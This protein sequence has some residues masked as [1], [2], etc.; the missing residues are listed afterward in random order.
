[1]KKETYSCVCIDDDR[2]FLEIL[3]KYIKNLDFLKLE[4][5]FTNPML[6]LNEVDQ[7]KPDIIFIDIDLP[8]INGFTFIDALDYNPI[9]IMITSHWEHAD[10]A[11]K[12]GIDAFITKPLKGT[13]QFTDTLFNA[14]A[15]R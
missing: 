15:K 1:M 14:I 5:T 8:E 6:A 7:S 10:T 3:S 13:E 12:H 9:V 11:A 2:L 4:A